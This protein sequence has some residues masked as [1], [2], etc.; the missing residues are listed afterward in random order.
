M[1]RTRRYDSAKRTAAAQATRQRVLSSARVLFGRHGIDDV[2]ISLIAEK[3]GVAP[4]TVFALFKSKDGILQAIMRESLFGRHFLVAQRLMEGIGDAA[5]LVALTA[6]VARAIYES[7]S[8]DLGLMRGASA[9]SPTLRRIER[10]FENMRYE[11]QENR[12][13]LLFQQGKAREGLDLETA[14]RIMWMYTSRDI[15]LMLVQ[16]GKWTPEAYETWLERTLCEAL[17]SRGPNS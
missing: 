14:R 7:E 6:K 17:V 8:R 9:F 4:A 11:M 13:R 2:T 10:R 16:E 3:A 15:Y 1:A 12:L 5:L